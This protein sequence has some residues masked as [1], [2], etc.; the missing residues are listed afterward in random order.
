MNKYSVILVDDESE[1]IEGIIQKV[2]F[3]SLGF[4]V[5]GAA[6]NG[7]EAYQLSL[8]L[9]PDIVMS[10]I[11]MPFMDGLSLGEK[12]KSKGNSLFLASSVIFFASSV[13]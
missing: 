1:I 7:E 12:L 13:K 8:K 6:E 2:D 4:I 11:I 10:D 5:V 9:K 3:E